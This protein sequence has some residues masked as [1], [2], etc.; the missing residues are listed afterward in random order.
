MEERFG[1][2]LKWERV[3][4]SFLRYRPPIKRGMLDR[5]SR[6]EILLVEDSPADVRLTEEELK[7]SGLE[8]NLNV[9]WDGEEAMEFLHA[10]KGGGKGALPDVILLDLNMP[11]KNG[12]EVLQDISC[13]SVLTNIP[14]VLLTVSQ[15]DQIFGSA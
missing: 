4:F 5:R 10:R 6:I 2:N 14:V 9:V 15:N 13:D 7:D 3:R 1:H 12:H 8:Y 11:K